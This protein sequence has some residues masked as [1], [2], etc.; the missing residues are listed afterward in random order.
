MRIQI[1]LAVLAWKDGV[2]D[3]EASHCVSYCPKFSEGVFAG[4]SSAFATSADASADARTT[5]ASAVADAPCVMEDPQI[6]AARNM[7]SKCNFK[8]IPCLVNKQSISLMEHGCCRV[9]AVAVG[10]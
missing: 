3:R 6:L 1:Q 2:L 8:P 9:R 4:R 7:R 5:A 10:S